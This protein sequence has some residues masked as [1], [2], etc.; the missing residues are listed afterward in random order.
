MH[1]FGLSAGFYSTLIQ[2]LE[3]YPST[4]FPFSVY[5]LYLHFVALSF[6]KQIRIKHIVKLHDRYVAEITF[7]HMLS[8]QCMRTFL[9]VMSAV[10]G[11]VAVS[12]M[13]NTVRLEALRI[14]QVR[15]GAQ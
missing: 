2:K 1:P 11:S 9:A 15:R 12:L 5:G 8:P 3:L 6:L 4:G 14:H 7:V 13:K 10:G